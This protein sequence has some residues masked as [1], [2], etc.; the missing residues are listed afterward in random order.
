MLHAAEA[1][2][3]G[4]T[5]RAAK[6]HSGVRPVFARSTKDLPCPDRDLAGVLSRAS[7]PKESADCGTDPAR[8]ITDETASE[9]T[10][11]AQH[12]I[13]RVAALLGVFHPG[14][15]G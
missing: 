2:I 10:D 8:F 5:G 11:A 7:E 12:L 13:D 4:R 14:A 6:T 9:A 15:N 1:L 3:F